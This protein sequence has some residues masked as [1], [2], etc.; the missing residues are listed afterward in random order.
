MLPPILVVIQIVAHTQSTF[1]KVRLI[2]DGALALDEIY[3]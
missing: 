3:V 1:I 2:H